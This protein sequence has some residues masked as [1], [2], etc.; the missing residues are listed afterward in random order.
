MKQDGNKA[1][2]KSNAAI[3]T[4]TKTVKQ[5]DFPCLPTSS[6]RSFF[7]R[8]NKKLPKMAV[9]IRLQRR[10]AK[11]APVYRMV[12]A[13]SRKPRDGRFLEILGIY[14]PKSKRPEEELQLKLDRVNHWLGVGAQPSDTA[15]SLIKKA[16]N[17]PPAAEAKEDV[18]QSA[19]AAPP[20]EEPKEEA[21]SDVVQPTTPEVEEAA[22]EPV[23]EEADKEEAEA[24]SED[25][26]PEELPEESEDNTSSD[27]E[28]EQVDPVDEEK[29]KADS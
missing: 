1:G 15:R 11:H 13:D 4:L 27:D 12:A 19:V 20:Q 29:D 25:S 10:G 22:E 16:R 8:S 24:V 5:L 9:R 28:V 7:L 3:I 21:P 6:H 18:E 14:N 23:S 26:V 2:V 17:A